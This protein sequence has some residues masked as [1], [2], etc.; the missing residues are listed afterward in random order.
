MRSCAKKLR[1][2]RETQRKEDS[3]ERRIETGALLA[4]LLHG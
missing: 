3:S 1:G 2:L 4:A